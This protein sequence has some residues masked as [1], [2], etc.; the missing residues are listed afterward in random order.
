MKANTMSGYS[1]AGSAT[2]FSAPISA[3]QFISGAYRPLQ[4]IRFERNNSLT[5]III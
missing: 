2:G 4:P 5:A 1:Y 3:G